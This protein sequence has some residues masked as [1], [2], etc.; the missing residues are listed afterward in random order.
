MAHETTDHN[1]TKEIAEVLVIVTGGT[2]SMVHTEMG[3][4]VAPDL[5]KRLKN[6]HCLH[7]HEKAAELNLDE[8]CLIT[9]L[10][11][12]KNYIKYKCLEFE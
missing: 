9:P 5:Y 10:T 11:P 7:D 1:S 4:D 8:D 6:V 2:L 12:Y 3:Y